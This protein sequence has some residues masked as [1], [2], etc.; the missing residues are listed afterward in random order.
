[1]GFGLW[2]KHKGGIKKIMMGSYKDG[3]WSARKF[4]TKPAPRPAVMPTANI[5]SLLR[6][7][8]RS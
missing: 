6:Q 7:Y 4:V 8:Q 2:K 1:M 3:Q 5:S